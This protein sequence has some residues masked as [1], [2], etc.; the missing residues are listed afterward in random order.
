MKPAN[1]RSKCFAK[2]WLKEVLDRAK[3][4]ILNNLECGFDNIGF[5]RREK[6]IAEFRTNNNYRDL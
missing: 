1:I 5:V 6:Q 3:E 4:D 2:F